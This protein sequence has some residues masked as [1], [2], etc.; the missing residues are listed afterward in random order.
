[1]AEETSKETIA[2]ME[3]EEESKTSSEP[4]EGL[5]A[6]TETVSGADT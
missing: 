1:M 2:G 3:T 4:E 6:E 5:E